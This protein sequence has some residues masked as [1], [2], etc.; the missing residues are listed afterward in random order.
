MPEVKKVLVPVDFSENSDKILKYAVEMAKKCEAKVVIV[1]VAQTFE[2][3]SDFFVPHVPVSQLENDIFESAKR[4]MEVFLKECLPADT[5]YESRIL[6]GDVAEEILNFAQSEEVDLIIM[7]THGYKGLE[8]VLF[9]SIAAKIV[10]M[11]HCPVLT[12]NPYRYSL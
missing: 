7:A 3:Y 1:F 12:V 8:K 10:K 2:D 4:K 9:G 11:A 5:P 6:A